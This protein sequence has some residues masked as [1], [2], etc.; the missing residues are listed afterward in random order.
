MKHI[1][2]TNEPF[3]LERNNIQSNVYESSGI[4]Y[5]DLPFLSCTESSNNTVDL[6]RVFIKFLYHGQGTSGNYGPGIFAGY[7]ANEYSTTSQPSLSSDLGTLL[8]SRCTHGASELPRTVI[9][10]L[11]RNKVYNLL[12]VYN[13]QDNLEEI[14]VKKVSD[15]KFSTS[16]IFYM[17]KEF[18]THIWFT[19]GLKQYQ[20]LSG[21]A[22]NDTD[23][24]YWTYSL[25]FKPF[26]WE[27]VRT[28]RQLVE[29]LVRRLENH[30]SITEWEESDNYDE[31]MMSDI[32]YLYYADY[33]GSGTV[34][35]YLTPNVY[36]DLTHIDGIGNRLFFST[37]SGFFDYD[38]SAVRL[39]P[40]TGKFISGTDNLTLETGYSDMIFPDTNPLIV[41]GHTYEF[42]IFDGVFN[43]ID[44]TEQS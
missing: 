6:S 27:K 29:F 3:L 5:N 40:I 8:A 33:T 31:I 44:V 14:W 9:F 16:Q 7:F 15:F 26:S 20:P 37:D 35:V 1:L 19:L 28:Q 25:E 30:Q 42:N 11:G 43:L 18:G 36:W 24:E 38:I 10:D 21:S 4:R 12:L 2:T 23:P 13:S 22:A 34:W 39:M 41:S 17:E 32:A